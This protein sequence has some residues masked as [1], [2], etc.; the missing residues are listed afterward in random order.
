MRQVIPTSV[1]VVST[2]EPV[3]SKAHN[4]ML[5]L[6]STQALHAY[7]PKMWEAT[8]LTFASVID[9]LIELAI[10]R[11]RERARNETSI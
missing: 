11:H 2:T 1:F 3:W 6:F 7:L 9:Q 5:P 8:G 10:D 4:I